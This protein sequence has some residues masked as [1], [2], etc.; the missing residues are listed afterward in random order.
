MQKVKVQLSQTSA[1]L[2]VRDMH[3]AHAVL[4]NILDSQHVRLLQMDLV[5]GG[6]SQIYTTL[7]RDFQDMLG[8]GWTLVWNGDVMA[9]LMGSRM[10]DEF[11]M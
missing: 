2:A 10:V 11:E 4:S 7:L 1:T 3:K 6:G 5:G 9:T 8:A